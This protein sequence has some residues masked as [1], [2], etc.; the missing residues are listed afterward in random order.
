MYGLPNSNLIFES[1]SQACLCLGV[2]A[3]CFH[4]VLNLMDPSFKQ[5]GVPAT[6]QEQVLPIS[7]RNEGTYYYWIKSGHSNFLQ[8]NKI[9]AM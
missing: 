8:R 6:R 4:G 7:H 9:L 1:M 5:E 3:Y 2:L